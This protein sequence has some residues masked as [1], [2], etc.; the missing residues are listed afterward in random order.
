MTE[1]DRLE[2]A[3]VAKVVRVE[4]KGRV[5]DV[6]DVLTPRD[7]QHIAG[8]VS[9]FESRGGR[10]LVVLTV[11]PSSGDSMERVGWAVSGPQSPLMMMIDPEQGSVRFEGSLPPERKAMVAGAMQGPIKSGRIAHAVAVGIGLLEEGGA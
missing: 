2:P 7:E 3:G 8:L 10:K 4:S 5:I 11:R 6:A 1:A 9:A